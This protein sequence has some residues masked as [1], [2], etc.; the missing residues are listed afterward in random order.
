[1]VT[2]PNGT[3]QTT[4]AAGNTTVTPAAHYWTEKILFTGSAGTQIVILSTAAP[5]VA[6]DVISLFIQKT[7]GGGIVVEVTNA[8]S[9]GTLLATFA[10]GTGN[11]TARF[12][13]VYGTIATGYAANAWVAQSYQ[14]PATN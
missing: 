11:N 14:I 9:G 10:D 5:P 4:N 8:T 7:D 2:A 12:D 3:A 13:F 1:M 6:G